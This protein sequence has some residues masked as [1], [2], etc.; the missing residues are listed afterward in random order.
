[1][2]Q[3]EVALSRLR[4]SSLVSCCPCMAA[5]TPSDV[6]EGM[7]WTYTFCHGNSLYQILSNKYDVISAERVLAIAQHQQKEQ[8]WQYCQKCMCL[9]NQKSTL[10][11]Q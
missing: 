5:Q 2:F 11:D 4:S 9:R 1:M 6:V 7:K 10:C 8:Y 3:S